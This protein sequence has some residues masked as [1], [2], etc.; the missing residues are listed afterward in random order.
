M[1]R[2]FDYF[3]QKIPA[4]IH[5]NTRSIFTE[6]LAIFIPD[7]FVM[8]KPMYVEEYHF[9]ICFSTPPLATIKGKEYQF[10]RGSLICLG[11]G[12][13]ILV[14]SS[15]H[16]VLVKYMAICVNPE[17][18]QDIHVQTGGKGTLQFST[19][20]RRFSFLLL[21]ALEALIHEVVTYGT[22]NQLM[23]ASLENRVAIQLLRDARSEFSESKHHQHVQENV[24][25]AIKY[26]ETYY[27]SNISITDICKSIYIS[28]AYL[29][30]IFLK[31]VGKTP[32]QYVMECRHQKSKELLET[33]DLS[34]EEI[35]RQVG[36]VNHSHFSTAF[37]K[38]QG[39]SPLAF[40]KSSRKI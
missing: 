37:K 13:D 8:D 21:E 16:S 27:S 14:H 22:S 17:F 32:H 34:V 40:R 10:R 20:D 30:K 35:A 31:Q 3:L 12:D 6:Y 15:S 28:P 39:V 19:V 29:Q 18:L 25:R 5:D 33:T 1:K 36:F 7:C 23:I 2:D 24:E 38:I 4:N 11:P 9:V 26:I